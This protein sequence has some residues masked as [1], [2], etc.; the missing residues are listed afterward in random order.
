[1]VKVRKLWKIETTLYPYK[2]GDKKYYLD[3]ESKL[4]SRTE[5]IYPTE[6]DCLLDAVTE[7][8]YSG[9]KVYKHQVVS[10]PH[11]CA[12][13]GFWISVLNTEQPYSWSY[14]V[15]SKDELIKEGNPLAE[16]GEFY[17]KFDYTTHYYV[18]AYLQ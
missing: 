11:E 6:L 12:S 17:E 9:L 15:Y 10:E 1:M 16:S 18:E 5:Y 7:P 8:E 14:R 4:N 13:R 3:T 2:H